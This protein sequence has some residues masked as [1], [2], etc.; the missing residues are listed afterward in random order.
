MIRGALSGKET[1]GRGDTCVH[2]GDSLC[3]MA[4]AN[5]TLESNCAPI[6]EEKVF[7]CPRKIHFKL[8]KNICF[9]LSRFYMDVLDSSAPPMSAT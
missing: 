5:T 3:R 8:Y 9:N 7:S 6:K 4:E 1:Q 2:V